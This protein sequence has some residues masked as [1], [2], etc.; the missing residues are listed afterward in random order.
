MLINWSDLQIKL[1]NSR[2]DAG[3]S[4]SLK[5]FQLMQSLFSIP[6]LL[7]SL[8]TL[9]A[10]RFGRLNVKNAQKC[11][12]LTRAFQTLTNSLPVAQ[13][14]DFTRANRSDRKWDVEAFPCFTEPCDARSLRMSV[15]RVCDWKRTLRRWP[16]PANGSPRINKLRWW[17]IGCSSAA[18][19]R[20]VFAVW[21][22]CSDNLGGK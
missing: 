11:Q 3:L 10:T 5:P 14:T 1:F 2:V 16:A 18:E 6:S 7:E 9:A 13:A 12:N 21:Y 15:N 8:I 20:K 19:V 4:T 17:G 22:N